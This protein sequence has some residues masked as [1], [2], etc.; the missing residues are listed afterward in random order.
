MLHPAGSQH[1]VVMLHAHGFCGVGGNIL[2]F[3][4]LADKS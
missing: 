4:R 2:A 1:Y 3:V